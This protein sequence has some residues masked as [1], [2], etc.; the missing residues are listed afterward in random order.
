MAVPRPVAYWSFPFVRFCL[1]VELWFLCLFE[2]YWCCWCRESLRDVWALLV[3]GHFESN[4]E[5]LN[6]L[7]AI[8]ALVLFFCASVFVVVCVMR[9]SLSVCKPSGWF[10]CPQ[11]NIFRVLEERTVPRHC[12]NIIACFFFLVFFNPLS[13]FLY[14]RAPLCN[15]VLIW[16]CGVFLIP[17]AFLLYCPTSIFFEKDCL[18][19]SCTVSWSH[20]WIKSFF[21][22]EN[23]LWLTCAIVLCSFYA[24]YIIYIC[25]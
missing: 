2:W 6:V 14:F 21:E 3:R 4:T 18:S 1:H 24:L 8:S 5:G 12:F 17:S 20:G 7:R 19:V 23:W 9:K 25:V 13:I 15:R 22:K 16:F 11:P 10:S